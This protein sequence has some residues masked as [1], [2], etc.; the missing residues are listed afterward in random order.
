MLSLPG[1]TAAVSLA[2]C[3][4]I[5]RPHNSRQSQQ[6]PVPSDTDDYCRAVVVLML[7]YP[8]ATQKIYFPYIGYVL[9]YDTLRNALVEKL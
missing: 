1:A 8:Y 4:E 7:P 3:D 9:K 6:H 2:E 5:C